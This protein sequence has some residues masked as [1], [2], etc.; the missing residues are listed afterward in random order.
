MLR[1]LTNPNARFA[2][3]IPTV[4]ETQARAN[5][6]FI[7]N[8]VQGDKVV[9]GD[10]TYT[11]VNALVPLGDANP[12]VIGLAGQVVIGVT[13]A[14]TAANFAAALTA[15]NGTNANM[16]VLY[17]DNTQANGDVFYPLANTTP[18]NGL[19]APSVFL[20]AIGAT[21]YSVV[22][23]GAVDFGASFNLVN[24]SEST[25]AVRLTLLADLVSLAHTTATM[26]GGSNPS[27]DTSITGNATWLEFNDPDTN[28]IKSP[29][30]DDQFN[31]WYFASPSTMPSYNTYD[32]IA[33]G[34][35][36]WLL[37]VP[38]PGCAPILSVAGGGNNLTLGN[39]SASGGDVPYLGN[40]IYLLPFTTPGDTQIQDVKF[41][42]GGVQGVIDP[43]A[44]FAAVLYEDDGGL[45][46]TLLNT[47]QIIT[48]VT[49]A[50]PNTSAFL[51]PTSL[52]GNTQYWLGVIVDT[53][54]SFSFSGPPV[55]NNDTA[56]FPVTFSNGPPGT[57][58]T[59]KAFTTLKSDGVNVANGDKVTI[60]FSTYT[61]VTALPAAGG[62]KIGASPD[63]TLQ[64]LMNAII[65]G[66]GSGTA[67]D[68][69]IVANSLVTAG[70]EGG[71]GLTITAL[72]QTTDYTAVQTVFSPVGSPPHLS[73]P[74]ATLEPGL[75]T[76]QSGINMWGDFVTSDI[77]ES[78]SY[79]Y[80]WVSAY[81]EEGPPSPPTILDGWSNGTWTLG[82]WQP[83]PDDQGILRN[84]KSIN[85]YR[86]VP[87][88]GGST[89]F[90]FVA[91]VPVGTPNY[92][93][94]NPNNTIALNQQ[95]ESTNWFPP[96]ENLQGLIAMQN[97]MV[98]GFIG[99]EIWFCVPFRPHAWDPT[100][101]LT[102][103]YPV[104]G[105][106]L[107]NG[108]L[109]VC[110]SANPFIISGSSPGNMVQQKCANAHPC[111]SRGS[112]LD[113]DGAVSYMSPNGLI[114]VT[115]AGVASNTTDLWFTRE[116]WQQLTPQKY[117]HAIFLASCYYA[118]GTDSPPSVSPADTSMAQKGFTI[119]LDQDNT[120]FTIWP[121]P[122]GHRLGFNPLTSPTGFDIQNVMS[123]PWTGIGMLIS[124]GDVWY[125]DFSDSNPAMIP[126]TW[127][128]KIYQQNAKRNYEAMKVFFKVPP[129]TPAQGQYR[130]EAPA[131]DPSWNTL[132]TGQWGII[133][134]FVDVDGT[135]NLTLIDA[136]EIRKSG[137]LLRIVDGFKA[138]QWQWEIDA[139]V[140]IS[141]VQIATTA[142]ELASV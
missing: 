37:G 102:V 139:R 124:N 10:L 71:L 30:V 121:Q 84:L 86:T 64:N 31:R 4:T 142:K 141:N 22:L 14:V 48:G 38:P 89:V 106:G 115:P 99:N 135:G 93:D 87:G 33:A 11:F 18:P 109:V 97:G 5:L 73:F 25:G 28:V 118:L 19:L 88:Q 49:T 34:N 21:N 26:V 24:V 116:N 61:F 52:I 90:F 125:F 137:E 58:P 80:T 23:F 17:G 92:V 133:K 119:E 70:P 45:P 54:N 1:T 69:G 12:P 46:S 47:G 59:E 101:T 35:P 110:T 122:G 114:Q 53:Q 44:K 127:V 105:L 123:D 79:V 16:G 42:L 6:V 134:T 138:E 111:L 27:F 9:V 98:A 120:S 136:R 56:K 128:S 50:N 57:A 140:N 112:I 67:Y 78:R 108:T 132:A 39:Y 20:A 2:Y 29:V 75:S 91:N 126:Y 82:L 130:N 7:T 74:L 51:N 83:P 3:R 100:T 63:I 107:T 8:P 103:D 95:L 113:G 68:A 131:S 129:N 96:P 13:A 62:V 55:G 77:I 94:K 43:N 60:G 85:I 76:S 81:N 104:V 117:T 41:N 15:D 36:A 66:P 40:F 65:G 32:R 72:L